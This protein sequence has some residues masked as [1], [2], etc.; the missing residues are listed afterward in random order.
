[1]QPAEEK[2]KQAQLHLEAAQKEHDRCCGLA[3]NAATSGGP[4]S[5]VV[6]WQKQLDA[7]NEKAK[8]AA[9][10][11]QEAQKRAAEKQR[12]R[13]QPVTPATA[14]AAEA[15]QQSSQTAGSPAGQSQDQQL[16]VQQSQLPPPQQQIPP[17]DPRSSKVKQRH[18]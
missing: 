6:H 13:R 1:M 14:T 12:Q 10:K 3:A 8:S 17:T 16:A 7:Y 4:D 11:L 5:Q 9:A 15:A 2:L 18:L